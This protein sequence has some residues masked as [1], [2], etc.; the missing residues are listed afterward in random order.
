MLTVDCLLQFSPAMQS[1][2]E[3][4]STMNLTMNSTMNLA[5]P[6]QTCFLIHPTIKQVMHALTHRLCYCRVPRCWLT[7]D[8]MLQASPTMQRWQANLALPEQTPLLRSSS[9]KTH[10]HTNTQTMLLQSAYWFCLS[11][12]LSSKCNHQRSHACTDTQ[13]VLLQSADLLVCPQLITCC[14]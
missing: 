5:L 14:R 4:N 8:Q 9:L 7:A 6:E 11:R 3:L 12:R 10:A 1:C 13:T 2:G